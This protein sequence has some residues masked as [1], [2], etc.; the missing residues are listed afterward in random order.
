MSGLSIATPFDRAKLAPVADAL[1]VAVAVA[2]PWSTSAV[3]VL[4][5]LWLLVL[6]PTL[7]WSEVRRELLSPAG[8]LPVLLFV[9]G[10][11]GMGWA[12]VSWAARW[13]GL[14]GFVKLLA[15]PLLM[16]QFRRSKNGHRV[17]LGFLI[18]CIALLFA[19]WAVAIWRDLPTG[20]T[21]FG[22]M[23][24]SY[25]VQSAE[26]AICAAG[27]L[28]LAVDAAQERRWTRVA[29]LV[30]IALAFLQDIFFVATGR[31]T[32]VI[33]PALIVVYG[34][35]RFGAKG[36]AGAIL[37]ALIL[38]AGVW[39]ASDHV[40]HRVDEILTADHRPTESGEGN[41]LG[42]AIRLL[43]QIGPLH[44]ERAADRTRN[45]LDHRNVQEGRRRS[46]RGGG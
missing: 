37:A 41:V 5:V 10:V 30:V 14:T 13:G 18:A 16:A 46:C 2:L 29:V 17:F 1:M 15:I 35:Q 32:L 20:S 38:A 11:I 8:G 7:E 33:I 45:R 9:L 4:L 23:V 36:V 34:A 44:R 19:S 26:F 21:D 22:V 24:K 42:R 12:D 28:Y 6:I 31:T 27:L 39:V 3:G 40:R 43:D 25:I